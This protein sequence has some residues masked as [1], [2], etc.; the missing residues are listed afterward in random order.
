[1]YLLFAIVVTF[2][3][4]CDLDVHVDVQCGQQRCVVRRVECKR[5]WCGVLTLTLSAYRRATA[6]SLAIGWP[7]LVDFLRIFRHTHTTH[8]EN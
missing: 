6:P 8:T 7:S 1:M 3:I 4:F 2:V 5:V